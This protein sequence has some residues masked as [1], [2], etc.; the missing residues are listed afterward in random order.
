[1]VGNT[2]GGSEAC[3]Q[4]DVQ[5]CCIKMPDISL[6]LVWVNAVLLVCFKFWLLHV[7][8]KIDSRI[9]VQMV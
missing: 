4:H 7:C 3:Q 2:P 6:H 9:L 1:M 5:C 8:I